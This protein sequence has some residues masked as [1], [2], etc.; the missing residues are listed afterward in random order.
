MKRYAME[1]VGTF[2]LAVAITLIG[3]PM[4]IGLMLM[5]MVYIGGHISGGHFNPAISFACFVQNRLKLADMGLYVAAQSF[6]ALVA[7][8]FFAMI[9]NNVYSLEMVPG[10][11]IAGPLSIEALFTLVLCW[12]YLAM[13]YDNRYKNSE[14]VGLVIGFTLMGIAFMGSLFNP[15]VSIASTVYMLFKE[16]SCGEVGTMIVYIVGPLL[17]A[18]GASFLFSYFKRDTQIY[19]A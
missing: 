8:W 6:G 15:A 12:V 4:G 17:G 2:F 1:F 13:N 14:H 10:N 5:A 19:N 11:Y 3:N 16:G 18:V 7:L 9:T